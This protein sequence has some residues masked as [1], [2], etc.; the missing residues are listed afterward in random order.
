MYL[1][2]Q[3]IPESI[4]EITKA[5]INFI[6]YKKHGEGL[7]EY[8]KRHEQPP[9]PIQKPKISRF[10]IDFIITIVYNH[11]DIPYTV[12]K[13]RKQEFGMPMS[14][15]MYFARKY[16]ILSYTDIGRYWNRDHATVLHNEKKVRTFME[17]EKEYKRDILE[18][19][20]KLKKYGR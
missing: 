1:S 10:P 2:L 18:I 17:V 16:T 12:T 8:R 9:Q 11:F 14:I 20:E 6:L 19:D 7:S 13:S 5:S 3:H 15:S 4:S